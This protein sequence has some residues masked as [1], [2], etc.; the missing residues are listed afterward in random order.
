MANPFFYLTF[1]DKREEKEIIAVER[2]GVGCIGLDELAGGLS[3]GAS[4]TRRGRGCVG[5]ST[6]A[7]A[8]L[9]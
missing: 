1:T 4:V 3:A 9:L 2:G 7:S 6:G 8:G 5:R